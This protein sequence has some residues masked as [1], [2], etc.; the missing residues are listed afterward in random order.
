MIANDALVEPDETVL[1]LLA[2]AVGPFTGNLAGKNGERDGQPN[3]KLSRQQEAHHHE[4]R[5]GDRVD[6]GIAKIIQRDRAGAV[7]LD[8]PV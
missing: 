3:R 1:L 8:D 7:A 6:D 2:N 5:I 4:Q